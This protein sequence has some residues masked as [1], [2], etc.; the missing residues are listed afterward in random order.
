MANLSNRE[1]E[2]AAEIIKGH[3]NR[4]VANNLFIS[5]KT[6]KFHMTNILSKVGVKSRAQLILEYGKRASCGL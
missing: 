3:S 4:E 6:V 2:V 1:A 5:E